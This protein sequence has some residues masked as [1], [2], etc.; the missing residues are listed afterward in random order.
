VAWPYRATWLRL[1]RKVYREG[2]MEA[3]KQVN[4]HARRCHPP[5]GDTEET[6]TFDWLQDA[7]WKEAGKRMSEMEI[8][9][10]GG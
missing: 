5:S 4:T 6:D 10:C 2:Q 8:G 3:Q 7:I 1:F 9:W